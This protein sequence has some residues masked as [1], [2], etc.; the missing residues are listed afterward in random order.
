[1]SNVLPP[2]LIGT[3]LQQSH[4]IIL[5]FRL[6]KAA[7]DDAIAELDTLSEESYK[8]STLIMQLLRDN[9]TLW[10]SDMQGDG[11]ALA[12]LISKWGLSHKNLVKIHGP[13]VWSKLCGHLIITSVCLG[14]TPCCKVSPAFLAIILLGRLSTRFWSMDVGIRLEN[15][16]V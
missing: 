9:L 4:A 14:W 13:G 15:H 2:C 3:A 8:D 6:A 1:M 5:G 7:F 11:K 12:W 16:I 10:T